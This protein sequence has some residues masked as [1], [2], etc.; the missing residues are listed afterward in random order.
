MP[1]RLSGD[2]TTMSRNRPRLALL[3]GGCGSAVRG[4][5]RGGTAACVGAPESAGL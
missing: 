1:A 4:S 5:L 3:G 2:Q